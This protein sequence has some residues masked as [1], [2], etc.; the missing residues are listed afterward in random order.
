MPA[1]IRPLEP[2]D[3]E[4]WRSLWRGYLTFYRTSLSDAVYASTWDRL[5]GDGYYDARGLIAERNGRAVGLAHYYFQR[6]GWRV[7]DVTYLQDLYAEPE[8]RGSGVGRALIEAVY[9]AADEAGCPT[10][11]WTTEHDNDVA[12]RL[13]DRVATVT[14]FIKYQR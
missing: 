9:A 7:E 5:M 8:A 14:K 12:R 11:Y 6:H 13:Y 4:A 1:T 2:L 10:V 3:Y